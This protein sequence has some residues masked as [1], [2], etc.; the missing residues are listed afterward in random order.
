MAHGIV[1]YESEPDLA[2]AGRG[3]RIAESLSSLSDSFNRLEHA[4]NTI[5]QKMK[6]PTVGTDGSGSTADF[7]VP[8]QA[9]RTLH[10]TDRYASERSD[11]IMA[12]SVITAAVKNCRRFQ[13]ISS[14]RYLSSLPLI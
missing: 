1:A 2:V 4:M 13:S 6:T 8:Q 7:S 12:A 14:H 11:G 5:D 10:E 9:F 3:G